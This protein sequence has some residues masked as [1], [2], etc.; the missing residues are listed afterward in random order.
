TRVRRISLDTA[1]VTTVAGEYGKRGTED[2]IGSAAHFTA[3]AG[4]W[5]D[6]TSI[7]VSDVTVIRKITPI[8]PAYPERNFAIPTNGSVSMSTRGTDTQLTVGYAKVHTQA[9]AAVAGTAIFG[10][11][12][13]GVLVTEAGVPATR[14][15]RRGRIY[16]DTG[17]FV[18]TGVAIVNPNAE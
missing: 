16:T 14:P 11:R 8:P 9:A 18:R 15:L 2:G 5:S 3:P 13:N 12:Q 10:F 4:I 7:Y 17:E 6:G 1:E